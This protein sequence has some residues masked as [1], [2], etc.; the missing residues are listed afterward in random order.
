MA[1]PPY[2]PTD[3]ERNRVLQYAGFGLTQEQI[4]TLVINP[5]TGEPISKPTLEKAFRN[6]LD[7][8]AAKLNAAVAQS[9]YK[10]ATGTGSQSVTAAIF[11]AKSRMG[12]RTV[13]RTELTGLD[14][15]PLTV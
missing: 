10:Q 13:D 11:W 7:M 2:V 12:W 14:G 15:V 4:C 3:A 5:Q 6:E 1:R 8:G 9:L